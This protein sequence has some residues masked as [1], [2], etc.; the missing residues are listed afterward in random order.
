MNNIKRI[1]IWPTIIVI[2]GLF[3]L[4]RYLYEDSLWEEIDDVYIERIKDDGLRVKVVIK[5]KGHLSQVCDLKVFNGFRPVTSLNE[6]VVLYGEPDNYIPEKDGIQKIEYWFENG[7]VDF[8]RQVIASEE[9]FYTVNA[10]PTNLP[11]YKLFYNSINLRIDAK[12]EKTIVVIVDSDNELIM[13]ITLKG[14][15]VDELS[16]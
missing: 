12:R 11:Y 8:V 7:R 13:V 1:P 6:A 3:I 10:Y 2:I 4:G 15:R 5:D 14:D 16:W 9:V